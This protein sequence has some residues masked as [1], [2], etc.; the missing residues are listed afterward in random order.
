M[1]R[2]CLTKPSSLRIAHSTNMKL[3]W[4]STFAFSIVFAPTSSTSSKFVRR[5]RNKKCPSFT[6]WPFICHVGAQCSPRQGSLYLQQ[7]CWACPFETVLFLSPSHFQEPTNSR[8]QHLAVNT[9]LNTLNDLAVLYENMQNIGPLSPV[10]KCRSISE[11]IDRLNT[12]WFGFYIRLLFF[13]FVLFLNGQ[14]K[15]DFLHPSESLMLHWCHNRS[16]AT[17][18]PWRSSFRIS[19]RPW[20]C[21]VAFDAPKSV[22]LWKRRGAESFCVRLK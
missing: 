7:R 12:L 10:F 2:D 6:T 9:G 11:C 14:L 16:T 22:T 21:K 20:L 18:N 13:C 8:F 5:S 15:S 1:C 17:F 3:T 19:P 4:E